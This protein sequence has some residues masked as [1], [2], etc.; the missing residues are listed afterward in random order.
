[1]AD[2]QHTLVE[3]GRGGRIPFPPFLTQREI[4][5]VR[6]KFVVRPD[7]VF[8]VTYPRSGTTW[9]EQIVHLL[10]RAG[11][12]GDELLGDAVPWLETL[13]NRPQG[14]DGF[15]EGRIG[16]RLFT[17]HL[18]RSLM[19]GAGEENGR[20]LY[21]AR[22]PKDVAV[23]C[24]HHDRSKNDYRGTWDEWFERFARGEV[25][26]GS[27]FDHVLP[28]WEESGRTSNVLFLRYEDMKRDLS[29]IVARIAEFIGVTADPALIET[30]VEKSTLASMAANPKTD[31]HWVP[32]KE[33]VPKHLRK[34]VVGD[35]RG[36][37]SAEQSRRLDALVLEKLSG[38]GLRFDFG[39]GL[40]LP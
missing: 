20:Y 10:D 30:V 28:W 18:P 16:R 34:G 36:T 3:D 26:F 21:V 14:Y 19:P 17:S 15:L 31:F 4:D 39:E 13:P 22:N 11:E 8:V 2:Y 40:L 12:Q 5:L 29:E 7:D 35:W 27:F 1:V 38:T 9:T 6:D 37:F 23:S 25:L 33:G 24:F 32:Q